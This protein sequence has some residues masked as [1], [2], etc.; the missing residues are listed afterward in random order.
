MNLYIGGKM[1]KAKRAERAVL[2]YVEE[3]EMSY[4]SALI[5]YCE[6]RDVDPEE[7]YGYLTKTIRKRIESEAQRLNLITKKKKTKKRDLFG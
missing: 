3:L 6:T 5:H 2:E 7:I 1:D 4:L